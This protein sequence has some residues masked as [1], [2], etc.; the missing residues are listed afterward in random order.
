M[1]LGLCLGALFLS[2]QGCAA[3]EGSSD[4]QDEDALTGGTAASSGDFA[5]VLRV[6]TRSGSC[7]GAKVGPAHVLLAAHCV[8]DG[9]SKVGD[10]ITVNPAPIPV[11]DKDVDVKVRRISIHPFWTQY[12]EALNPQAPPDVA[13]IEVVPTKAF[14]RI[15][16][17]TIDTSPLPLGSVVTLTGYGCESGLKGGKSSPRLRTASTSTVGFDSVVASSSRS[18]PPRL[19]SSYWFTAGKGLAPAN[20]S[21]CPGDSGGP[22]YLG[23]DPKAKQQKVVGINAYYGFSDGGNLSTTNW[24]TR[25]DGESR[26]D[27][28]SWLK[29]IG[30]PVTGKT[31]ADHYANC[32][33]VGG[34]SVC[35]A[36]RLAWQAGGGEARYGSPLGVARFERRVGSLVWSQPF[37]R[38]VLDVDAKLASPSASDVREAPPADPKDVCAFARSGDRGYCGD[39]L[40]GGD[41]KVVYFC[42]GVTTVDTRLCANGC[43]WDGRCN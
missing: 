20:A 22:V 33:D 13:V 37:A 39:V 5:S 38:G 2:L 1:A 4:A 3:S 17:A 41:P 9:K 36:I 15:P 25:L 40:V 43:T 6:V 31:S 32:L 35:G 10:T 16:Q 23:S 12:S 19:G 27:T 42:E 28:A 30:V 29:G 8:S 11:F 26:L 7:T 24:H 34:T 18:V 14:N 21:I